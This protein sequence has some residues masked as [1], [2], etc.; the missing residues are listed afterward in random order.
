MDANWDVRSFVIVKDE[1][2]SNLQLAKRKNR[3]FED[4]VG[5]V[6]AIHVNKIKGVVLKRR[7][8]AMREI[9]MDL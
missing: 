3:V 9:A 6:V 7:K 8:N 2:S 1:P 4:R 5:L